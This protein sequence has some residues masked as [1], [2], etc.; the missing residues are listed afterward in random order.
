MLNTVTTFTSN[1]TMA[2]GNNAGTPVPGT[3]SGTLVV[4]A[5]GGV[6]SFNALKIDKVGTGYT[7]AASATGLLPA[8]STAFNVGPGTATSLTFT[9]QPLSTAAITTMAPIGVTAFDAQGN[10]AT[11]FTANVTVALGTIPVAGAALHGTTV[12]KAVAGVAT[13]STLSVDSVGNGYTMTAASTGLTGAVSTS[14]DITNGSKLV[15]T[16]QPVGVNAGSP[17]TPAIQVTAKDAGNVTLTAFTGPVT[18]AILGGTGTAGAVLSGT[19]TVN[20]VAGVATFSNLS[21][22]LGGNG[23][24]LVVS[25]SGLTSATSNAFTINSTV[26]AATKLGFITQ[27]SNTPAGS[28]IAPGV[29][30]A[31]QDAAGNTVKGLTGT[32][33]VAIGTNPASGTLAGTTTVN[34]NAGEG[35]FPNLSINNVG[36]G[37]TLTATTSLALTGA[38]ST[39]F[40]ITPAATIHLVFTAQPS[41]TTAGQNITPAVQVT[42]ENASNVVVTSFTQPITMAIA[43][44]SGA[45]GATLGGTVTVSAVNGVATFSNLVITKSGSGFKLQATSA[46][47]ASG[48]SASFVINPDVATTLHFSI[49]PTTG[50]HGTAI[51][52][53][54]QVDARD[55][56][57]NIVKAFTGN[58]TLAIA[59]GTGTAGAVLSGTN[60]VPAVA[61]VA[62]FSNLSIN[63]VGTGYKLTAAA[64]GLT[65]ATSSAFSEN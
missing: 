13:F 1:I 24:K 3:L 14:F 52:P 64:T 9:T 61:G 25:S 2:I 51:T 4:K 17:I 35:A 31:V 57:N 19:L 21:I 16:V 8:T 11:G 54:V 30:V 63:L 29:V 50:L 22:N 39:P 56:F 45:N 38:T 58:V 41:V 7:L 59:S 42:A 18:I 10:V 62:V 36:T 33:T 47:T 12:I 49:Q 15:F 53:A 34:I 60:P 28:A 55:Q 27:P 65:G 6:S 48:T 40:N 5:A 43:A 26:G 37:Y 20:A 23:Y 46:G 32:I 44:G